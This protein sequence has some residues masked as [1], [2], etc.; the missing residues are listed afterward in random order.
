M[1][2]ESD[3]EEKPP[4]SN[5]ALSLLADEARQAKAVLLSLLNSSSRDY[6]LMEDR[7]A[8]YKSCV[9]ASDMLEQKAR[10]ADVWRKFPHAAL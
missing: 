10:D 6:E 3:S 7:L 2:T 1:S 8:C 9:L 4:E 5:Y